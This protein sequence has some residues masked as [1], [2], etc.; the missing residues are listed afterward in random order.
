MADEAKIAC[1]TESNSHL[2]GNHDV[3]NE[4]GVP[5]TSH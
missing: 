3:R 4:V 5:P 2:G 1:L